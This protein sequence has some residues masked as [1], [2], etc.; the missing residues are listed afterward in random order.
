MRLDGRYSDVTPEWLS[1]SKS[2]LERL[3]RE[4]K[5]LA[6]NRT[7]HKNC[8]A[9]SEKR[10]KTITLIDEAGIIVKYDSLVEAAEQLGY[11]NI[12]GSPITQQIKKAG[13]LLADGTI[14]VRLRGNIYRV[15]IEET[16]K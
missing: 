1:L 7:K 4:E 3:R 12:H 5:K 14:K 10:R 11:T 13:I 8:I 2:H 9:A 16:K 6:F 15:I